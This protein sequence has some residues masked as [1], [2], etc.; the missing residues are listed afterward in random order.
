MGLWQRKSMCPWGLRQ[1]RLA[2][3]PSV[4][5]ALAPSQVRQGAGAP[6][7]GPLGD[8]R[9]SQSR[10]AGLSRSA[11]L[12][13]GVGGR[14]RLAR[15]QLQ[16]CPARSHP[17]V[18]QLTGPSKLRRAAPPPCRAAPRRGKAAGLQVGGCDGTG[19]RFGRI[20]ALL[21]LVLSS[22][23]SSEEPGVGRFLSAPGV[24]LGLGLFICASIL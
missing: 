9:M 22:W 8:L 24:A 15:Y 2:R 7:P 12:G 21:L 17:P 19:R 16:Q 14:G 6:T 23:L 20:K 11:E 10:A 1:T 4:S 3:T 13:A 5:R 18:S